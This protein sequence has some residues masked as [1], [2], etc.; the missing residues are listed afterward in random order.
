MGMLWFK[1]VNMCQF[2]IPVKQVYKDTVKVF[3]NGLCR[4]QTAGK[5]HSWPPRLLSIINFFQVEKGVWCVCTYA[6]EM[7]SSF[8]ALPGEFT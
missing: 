4:H 5:Q 1:V 3:L 6:N 7:K 8:V 2:E